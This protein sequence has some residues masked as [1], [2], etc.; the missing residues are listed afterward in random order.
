MDWSPHTGSDSP[1]LH[2]YPVMMMLP[3]IKSPFLMIMKEDVVFPLCLP[4]T[5]RRVAGSGSKR[6]TGL[7]Q[8]SVFKFHNPSLELNSK[9]S[10]RAAEE[11]RN[12]PSE[13]I[14]RCAFSFVP[15]EQHKTAMHA[16]VCTCRREARLYIVAFL[17]SSANWRKKTEC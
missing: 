13:K 12:K 15:P 17:A 16:S 6:C 8:G 3:S 4:H 2:L 1:L 9:R 11:T 7:I 14:T 5:L 10:V